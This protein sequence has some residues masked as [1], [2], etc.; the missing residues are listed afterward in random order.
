MKCS[1]LGAHIFQTFGPQIRDRDTVPNLAP[2]FNFPYRKSTFGTQKWAG[3]WDCFWCPVLGKKIHYFEK[4]GPRWEYS[5]GRSQ[6]P[7]IRKPGTSI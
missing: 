2:E 3:L 7:N 4:V 6:W 1:L 5:G